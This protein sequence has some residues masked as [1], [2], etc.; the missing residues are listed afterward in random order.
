MG[1]A[2]KRASENYIEVDYKDKVVFR[3]QRKPEVGRAVIASWQKSQGLW[4]GHPV[5]QGM[6]VREVIEWL[7]GE[8]CDV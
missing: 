6:T 7:R 1:K 4:V 3:P 5:F 2:T 8:D